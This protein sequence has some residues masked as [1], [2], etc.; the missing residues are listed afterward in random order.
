MKQLDLFDSEIDTQASGN[1][2]CT[3]LPPEEWRDVSWAEGYE[4]SSYGRVASWKPYRNMAKPPKT[5]RLLTLSVDKDGYQKTTLFQGKTRKTFRVCRL[6]AT[7]WHGEPPEGFVVRHL[8]GSKT[9]DTP[10]NLAWGTPQEN[11]D[12]MLNHGTRVVGNAVNTSRLTE[13]DVRLILKSDRGH[14][15]LAR[16]FNVTPCAI[17]H[18]RD[19]RTWKHVERS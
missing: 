15:D 13:A 6:V 16:E 8:D 5:R 3:E 10:S 7:A 11:S 4:V 2:G 19:G 1:S 18:I 14:S 17:W 12:D 9:N